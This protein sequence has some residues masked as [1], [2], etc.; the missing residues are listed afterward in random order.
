MVSKFPR[1]N[2]KKTPQIFLVKIDF[3]WTYS[4]LTIYTL[5]A[6]NGKMREFM[7]NLKAKNR[8]ISICLHKTIL[9]LFE[10]ST[11]SEIVPALIP[12]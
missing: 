3:F 8:E 11:S 9:P 12:G 10:L 7:A 5:N 4:P 1:F 2:Q 6:K